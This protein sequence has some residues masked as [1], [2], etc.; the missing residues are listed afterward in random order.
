MMNWYVL[1]VMTGKEV[2]VLNSLTKIYDLTILKCLLPKK[3]VTEKK[4]GKTYET[5]KILFP[6][7]VFIHTLMTPNMYYSLRQIPNILYLVMCGER[8]GDVSYSYFSEISQNEMYWILSM[9]DQQGILSRSEVIINNK[10]VQVISGPLVGME[11][12]IIKLDKRKQRVKIAVHFL[13]EIRHVD[14]GVHILSVEV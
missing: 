7:Y 10:M 12:N 5:L 9:T 1:R 14:V 6:G 13:G 11:G 4:N 3:E 2:E 8:K